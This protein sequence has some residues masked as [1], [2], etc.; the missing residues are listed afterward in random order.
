MKNI[1]LNQ[2]AGNDASTLIK[3]ADKL[4][5]KDLE[6]KLNAHKIYNVLLD[7]IPN[8]YD[9]K[10]LYVLRGFLRQKI[11]DCE[12]KFFWNE[13]FYSQSGQDK[14]IKNFF[15]PNKKHGFFVEVG[16]YNG[17][18]G[19]NCF[20]FEKYL[21]WNGIAFE[22]SIIQFEKL[23]VNRNCLL[24]NKAIGPLEKEV[25]FIEVQEGLSQMSGINDEN[26]IGKDIVTND[27]KSKI[28]KTK[29][30]TTTFEKNIQENQEIDYLSVD[31][32]GGEMELIESIDF[33]K[34]SIKV[35]SVE[36]YP[37]EKQNFKKFFESKNFKY[38]ERIGNDEIFYNCKFFN[39]N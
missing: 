36:N 25:E 24:I 3:E 11:W 10:R 21:N 9:D 33:N 5:S 37:P 8:I 30:H 35:I 17:I 4:F 14:I 32:E 7:E 16:A 22:P 29:I 19:S 20:H 15:F 27:P 13:K 6:G 12:R 23:K 39:F 18:Q 38:F 1:N 28:V 31:I 34:F 26:F 2:F